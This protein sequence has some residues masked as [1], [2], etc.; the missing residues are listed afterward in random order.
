[1]DISL[2]QDGRTIEN[3]AAKYGALGYFDTGFIGTDILVDILFRFGKADL[4]FALLTNEKMG[5]YLYM[6]RA[7]A[8]TLW[9]YFHGAHSRCHP[10]FGAPV[11]ALF[12]HILGI[13]Q[14]EGNPL[15]VT[16]SPL[17]PK[18]LGRASGS[19][20][21]G[22]STL[23]TSIECDSIERESDGISFEIRVPKGVTA[24]FRYA[25]IERGL[26]AGQTFKIQV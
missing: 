5:G 15:Q 19:I 22:G 23:Y 14:A 6:K 11:R 2:Q 4:A 21:I 3:L 25:G 18:G 1:L 9:E 16:V 26:A 8:T 13:R 7:G 10:M 17:L 20:V 12:D 24:Q